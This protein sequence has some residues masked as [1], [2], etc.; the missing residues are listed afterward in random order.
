MAQSTVIRE[1][2]VALGFKIDTPSAEKF[3]TAIGKAT[4]DA[5]GLG[6][7]VLAT[8][9]AVEVMVTKVARQFEDLYYL[10]QRTNS[11]VVALQAWA[12]G[13]KQIGISSDSARSAV[14]GLTQAMRLSPG[15]GGLLNQLGVKTAGRGSVQILDDVLGR[16]KALFPYYQAAGFANTLGIPEDVLQQY[17]NN[18]QRFL[19][20]QADS[21]RRQGEAGVGSTAMTDKFNRFWMSLNKLEDEFGILDQRIASDFL[22]LAQKI[23]DGTETVVEWFVRLDRATGGLAGIVG[24]FVTGGLATM[25]AKYVLMR[26]L[27]RG[28]TKET[29]ELAAAQKVEAAAATAGAEATGAAAAGGIGV[30]GWLGAVGGLAAAFLLA[31]TKPA[32]AGEDEMARQ[33]AMGGGSGGGSGTLGV[34]SNNPGN[35]QLRGKELQF[36]SAPQGMRAMADL[37]VK[38]GTRWGWDSVSKIVSTWAPPN[39]NDTAAYISDVSKRTGFGPND[40]LNLRDPTTLQKVMDAMINHEQGGNP[41]GAAMEREAVAGALG[42]GGVNI[43]QTNNITVSGV[44]DPKA[45][46]DAVSTKQGVVNNALVR[47]FAGVVQ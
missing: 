6:E 47:N 10:S 20:A 43:Q 28:L 46:A 37:L 35:I 42:G 14:E 3:Q 19:A 44:S 24:A 11:S 1:F 21:Q 26:T 2:L 39:E 31:S 29:L 27:L 25:L 4:K 13:A 45:A 18:P 7:A 32:N 36:P 16:L 22:P 8:A 34:R 17:W 15:V 30:L 5:V 40:K 23:V 41:W 9:A 12:F 33:K 38:Y